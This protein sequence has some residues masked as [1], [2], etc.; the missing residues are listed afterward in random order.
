METRTLGPVGP[1]SAL[2]LGGGGIGA[3]WGETSRAEAVATVREAVDAGITLLDL[4][5]SY[6]DGEA[7]RVVGETFEGSLPDGVLVTTKCRLGNP[8]ADQVYEHLSQSLDESLERI[9]VDHVDVY[10]LHANVVADGAG[11]DRGTPLTLFREAVR[12]AFERLVEEG[13]TRAWGISG[14]GWPSVVR[15]ILADDPP[16]HVVQCIANLLDSTGAIHRADEPLAPRESIRLARERG[17]GVM[18]IRAVQAGALTDGFDRDLPEDHADWA[19]FRRAEPFRA[20]AAELGVGT[21]HLAH[22][23]SLTMEGVDTVVLGVKNR[24]ELRDC[25]A[26]EAAGPLDAA[27]VDRID[28]AVGRTG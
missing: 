10:L 19:D 1:V 11:S 25:L 16:P 17:V 8:P 21:A 6:G 12:P 26:A 13:R 23:Y 15:T 20:I 5:P 28:A 24:E 14:I 7:E 9:R 18:G 3:V 4:A 27:L 2:A 22:R